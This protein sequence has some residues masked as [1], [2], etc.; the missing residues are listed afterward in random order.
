MKNNSHVPQQRAGVNILTDAVS[1]LEAVNSRRMSLD[2][3]LDQELAHPEYRRTVSDLLF[4]VFRRQKT[5]LAGIKAHSKKPP[6]PAVQ[7]ILLTVLAQITF[8]SGIAKESALNIAVDYTKNNIGPFEAKFVNAL[9]RN[10]LR[11]GGIRLTDTPA[12]ILPQAVLKRWQERFSEAELLSLTKAFLTPP[13][14]TFRA[15]RDLPPP[16]GAVETVSFG[17]FRFYRTGSP[18]EILASPQL[19]NG[20]I[21]IQ[22]PAT[23]L[24]PSLPDYSKVNHALDLCSAPGGKSLM[25]GERLKA[26]AMLTAADRSARRQELTRKNFSLRNLPWRV[27][28]AGADC[29]EGKYDLILADVPCSNTGVFRRRPD[30]LWRYNGSELARVM[31]LQREIL[32]NIPRLLLPGG[33]FVYSTCSIE[34]QEN[35]RQVEHFLKAHP[36]FTLKAEKQLYPAA[37]HDGAYAALLIREQ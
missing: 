23:S 36:D 33:Q 6:A 26:G 8:Q 7:N 20:E 4:H 31:H 18:G 3:Y 15:E 27:V 10:I 16:A 11:E 19:A 35:H 14:F 32:E 25:L 2:D 30:A 5:L 22:D 37:E 28:A 21:Y 13:E 17:N 1:A 12:D 29:I 9:V 34:E 24:A